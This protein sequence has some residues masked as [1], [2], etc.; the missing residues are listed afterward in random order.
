MQHVNVLRG[1]Y[2]TVCDIACIVSIVIFLF[3]CRKSASCTHVSALLHGLIEITPGSFPCG[4]NVQETEEEESVP[5]TSQLCQWKI[6]QKRKDSTQILMKTPFKKY[7]YSKQI[8]KR[9]RLLDTFDPR[10]MEFRGTASERRRTTVC[11]TL[12]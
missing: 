5:V 6:P 4:G 2:Y 9:I 8:K 12:V 3:V 1:E 7:D 10:P 11:F